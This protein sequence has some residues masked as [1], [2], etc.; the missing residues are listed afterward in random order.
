MSNFQRKET[1]VRNVHLRQRG[2]DEELTLRM[3]VSL[4]FLRWEFEPYQLVS[5]VKF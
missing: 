2:L 5:D 1:D 3:S 4:Y